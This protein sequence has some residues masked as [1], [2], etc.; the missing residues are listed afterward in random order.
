[1]KSLNKAVAGNTDTSET[2]ATAQFW[3]RIGVEMLR[4]NCRAFHRRMAGRSGREGDACGF[5]L[6]VGGLKV[7]E[8]L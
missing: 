1:M 6:D 2:V 5:F 7:A 3:Q 4:G 8:G